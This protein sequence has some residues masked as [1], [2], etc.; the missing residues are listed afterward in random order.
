M[1]E[2]GLLRFGVIGVNEASIT[3]RYNLRESEPMGRPMRQ[4]VGQP[5]IEALAPI[6]NGEQIANHLAKKI[7][8]DE[9]SDEIFACDLLDRI[10]VQVKLRIVCDPTVR[11]RYLLVERS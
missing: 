6:L 5:V 10:G 11:T 3:T 2:I 8:A 4:T 9:K 7:A 1:T